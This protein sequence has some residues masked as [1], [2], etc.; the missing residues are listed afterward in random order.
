MSKAEIVA[1]TMP[2][3]GLSMTEG[4][5]MEW[6]VEEGAVLKVGDAMVDIETEK[7]ANTFEALD[8]GTLSKIVATPDEILP[9]GALL[10]VLTTSEISD[11]EITVFVEEFQANYVPP[12]PE[13]EDGNDAYAFIEVD[14]YKIRYSKMGDG[15]KNII[16]IHGFG[17]DS[18]R[19]LFTQ[20]PLSEL[21]TVYALD[22]PGHGQSTKIISDPS[23][24]GL[25]KVVL[26]F[27]DE[28][29]IDQAHLIGHSL[30]GAIALQ[31]AELDESRVTLL[32]L[33]APVGLGSEINV[34]YINE[35]ITADSRKQMKKALQELV[36]D[37]NLVNRSLVND[38]L[39]FKRTDGVEDALKAIASQFIT[40]EGTQAENFL[41]VL[42]DLPKS[43]II[44]G[45]EDKI[46]P[47]EHC[48]G[49][50]EGASVH[51]LEGYGHLVQ[52]EA[53]NEVNSLLLD[54]I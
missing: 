11:E 4:K 23:V 37:P 5:I 38:M 32:S 54:L 36:A 2:K 7:I 43:M 20:Q 16:L 41:Q 47:S 27:M 15:E 8:A 35:F 18:D 1:I 12:E 31:I 14:N 40:K 44:W 49:L 34:A 21:A 3:W 39:K 42:S 13:N 48:N 26:S 52:L 53:A 10:G 9:I 45:S 22:L 50:E 19:W 46:I 17:G 33:I 30:G 28:L 6:L 24:R 25:A 29:G 51:I